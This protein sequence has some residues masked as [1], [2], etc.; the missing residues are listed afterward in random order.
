[1]ELAGLDRRPP[2]CDPYWACSVEGRESCLFPGL[3]RPSR[4]NPIKPQQRALRT[5]AGEEITAELA[6]ALSLEAE[7]GYDLS[8]AKR[9]RIEE[10]TANDHAPVKTKLSAASHD[11]ELTDEDLRAVK[12]ARSEP[13]TSWSDAAAEF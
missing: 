6:D 9:R 12:E 1:M 8:Q 5:K 7:Q 4:R 11:A 13:G 2:G 3:S 10:P